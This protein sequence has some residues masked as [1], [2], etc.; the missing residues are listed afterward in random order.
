MSTADTIEYVYGGQNMNGNLY[1]PSM[2]E[3]ENFKSYLTMLNFGSEAICY[4]YRKQ[5]LKEMC[6]PSS[7]I[8]SVEEALQFKNIQIDSFVF[9][10]GL[11]YVNETIVGYIM[12]YIE[13]K[14]LSQK[15][16]QKWNYISFINACKL[17]CVDFEGISD[18]GISAYDV[19]DCNI[20]YDGSKMHF[21]DTSDYF[22]TSLPVTQLRRQNLGKLTASLYANVCSNF[23]LN[24]FINSSNRLCKTMQDEE[25]LYNP[26][27]FL[28]QLKEEL[29]KECGKRIVT[30]DDAVKVLRKEGG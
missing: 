6:G 22:Y 15:P 28:K 19:F 23:D 3:W 18:L 12:P 11:I 24:L 16:I 30:L 4:R 27:L 14:S 25:L 7:D 9:I 10:Q 20:L 5:V 13:G 17:A 2:V 26:V 1:F 8:K 29:T 21:I